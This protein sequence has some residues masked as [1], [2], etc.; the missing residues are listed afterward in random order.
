MVAEDLIKCCHILGLRTHASQ[1]YTFRR[2]CCAV[3]VKRLYTPEVLLVLNTDVAT[4]RT[5]IYILPDGTIFNLNPISLDKDQF[6]ETV[7]FFKLWSV[8]TSLKVDIY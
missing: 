8:W 2:L 5:I 3:S 1:G 7:S 6:Y 4:K